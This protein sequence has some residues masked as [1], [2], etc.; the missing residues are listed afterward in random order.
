[1]LIGGSEPT[2]QCAG[3]QVIE[4]CMEVRTWEVAVYRA[5]AV[6]WKDSDTATRWYAVEEFGVDAHRAPKSRSDKKCGKPDELQS[7]I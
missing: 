1:M 4:N 7:Y 3:V 6:W 2:L 5:S